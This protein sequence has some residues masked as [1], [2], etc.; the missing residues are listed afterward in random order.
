MS[1]NRLPD[2]K[3]GGAFAPRNS[4]WMLFCSAKNAARNDVVAAAQSEIKDVEFCGEW[5]WG[6][7][8]TFSEVVAYDKSPA[9][10]R[11]A[12]EYCRAERMRNFL[13]GIAAE[14]EVIASNKP[15]DIRL[16]LLGAAS[17]IKS[18]RPEKSAAVASG[19]IKKC[20]SAIVAEHASAVADEFQ[21]TGG[22]YDAEESFLRLFLPLS[23]VAGCNA[24]F[25]DLRYW[26]PRQPLS[27]LIPD[28]ESIKND[29]GR[30][31]KDIYL[32]QMAMSR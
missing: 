18:P 14:C 8:G 9:A 27:T 7:P 31:G 23:S 2:G 12:L 20:L 21:Q 19:D 13:R 30:D 15:N 4:L 1:K 17:K 5:C 3:N 6:T 32:M 26:K 16:P 11:Q 29:A 28:D 22:G 10:F 25:C 24:S